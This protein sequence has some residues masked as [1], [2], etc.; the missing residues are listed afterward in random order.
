M[1]GPYVI[2]VFWLE[3]L[4]VFQKCQGLPIPQGSNKF[5]DLMLRTQHHQKRSEQCKKAP[6]HLE[7]FRNEL[8]K[9]GS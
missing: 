5:V 9:A 4:P 6:A 7:L 1:Q 8:T 3:F 2:F